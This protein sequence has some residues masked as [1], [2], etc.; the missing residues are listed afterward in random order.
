MAYS[1]LGH[2]PTV[3]SHNT[4]GLNIPEKRRTLLKE[5]KKG[6]PRFVFLQETHF[7]T[8]QIPKMTDSF[9]TQAYHATNDLAKSKGVSILI[10]REASFELTDKLIDPEGRFIFLKG[11]CCGKPITL[12]N[13]YFPNTAHL[14]FCRK[15]VGQLKDFGSGCII[16][17]GDFNVPLN[18]LSDTST[19][20]TY[21]TYKILKQ[22]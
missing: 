21:I 3:I 2:E 4:K 5:L 11:N 18:P 12:A 16:L 9:F 8:Q 10:G 13:V 6:K 17:G 22:I 7:K 20:K 1:S 15:I 19:G 14:T